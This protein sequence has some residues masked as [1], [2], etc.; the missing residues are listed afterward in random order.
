MVS[1]VEAR[2]KKKKKP[3]MQG[4][5]YFKIFIV[6]KQLVQSNHTHTSR[7]QVE[8]SPKAAT[9]MAASEAHSHALQVR[10]HQGWKGTEEEK[11]KARV[12][13]WPLSHSTDAQS[14]GGEQAQSN[15][16]SW[17]SDATVS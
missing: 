12:S 13:H 16:N 14:P 9:P 10:A 6:A 11:H 7:K 5:G 2:I 17:S 8:P 15:G 1:R 3:K 4:Q